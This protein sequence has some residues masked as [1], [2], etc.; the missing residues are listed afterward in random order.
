MYDLEQYY[1]P[2]VIRKILKT[3]KLNEIFEVTSRRPDKLEPYFGD[4]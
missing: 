3:T 4:P 2:P 1:L